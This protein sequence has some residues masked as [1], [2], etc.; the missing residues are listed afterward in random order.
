MV[1]GASSKILKTHFI[2]TCFDPS[3]FP[4]DVFLY[5]PITA[6]PQ[7]LKNPGSSSAFHNALA[8]RAAARP[9]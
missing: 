3:P 5:L 6:M 1:I 4:V 2:G 9:D 8:G 7:A